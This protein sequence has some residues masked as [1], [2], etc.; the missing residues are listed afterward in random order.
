MITIPSN[1]IKNCSSHPMDNMSRWFVGSSKSS[2]SGLFTKIRANSNLIFQPPEN[3]NTGFSKS[4]LEKPN[5][6]SVVSIFSAH[7]YPSRRSNSS[8]NSFNSLNRLR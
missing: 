4:S 1:L 3:S 7:L 5:P 6:F 8:F 2:I